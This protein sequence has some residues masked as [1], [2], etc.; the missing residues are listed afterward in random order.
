M[1]Y[2]RGGTTRPPLIGHSKQPQD[3]SNTTT[4][5][6]KNWDMRFDPTYEAVLIWTVWWCL[7]MMFLGMEWYNCCLVPRSQQIGCVLE[8][9]WK[10][11][12]FPKNTPKTPKKVLNLD[13]H[14]VRLFLK[15]VNILAHWDFEKKSF[16]HYSLGME[17]SHW[18]G[19]EDL[20]WEPLQ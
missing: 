15:I 11:P 16:W 4:M 2:Q 5:S 1:F 17:R 6:R 8:C 7:P 3:C 9:S 12:K 10:V 13:P 19:S 14:P 20:K 18:G